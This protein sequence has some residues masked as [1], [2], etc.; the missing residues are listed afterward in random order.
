M[1]RCL[2]GHELVTITSPA[3][4]TRYLDVYILHLPVKQK[5]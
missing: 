4:T 1:P 2:V 5:R 3:V